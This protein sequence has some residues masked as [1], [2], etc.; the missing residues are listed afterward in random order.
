MPTPRLR[1]FE[2]SCFF[3]LAMSQATKKN[4]KILV[5]VIQSYSYFCESYRA[6][7]KEAEIQISDGPTLILLK[8]FW[9][10]LGL[11][12]FVTSKYKF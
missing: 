2:H 6:Y 4:R 11:V 1:F 3:F 10:R 12:A 8:I 9:P 5:K 7:K